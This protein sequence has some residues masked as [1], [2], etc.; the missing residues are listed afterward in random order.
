[1]A[2]EKGVEF[3]I[4]KPSYDRAS[5]HRVAL[6]RVLLNLVTNALKFTDQGYVELGAIRSSQSSIEY[7]VRDTGR[8]ISPEAQKMLFQPFKKADHR[9]GHFFSGSG[10]GLS[11][12]RR[13]LR[14]M[15]SDLQLE[16]R[17]DWGTRF[18]FV[19]AD[20]SPPAVEDSATPE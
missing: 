8:G 4:E 10:L 14:A 17:P 16:T 12:V 18:H 13:L 5:G 9:E 7:Y 15:G 19:L 1:M 2:E 20:T 11:I 6:A 3:R